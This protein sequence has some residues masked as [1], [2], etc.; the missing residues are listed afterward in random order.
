MK[1]K[2]RLFTLVIFLFG[3][4]NDQAQQIPMKIVAHRGASGYLPE[5]TLAAAAMA[6]GLGVDYIEPDLVM[7]KDDQLV[8]LHDIH[9]DTTTNVKE[10]F[11]NRK[12]KD[13]RYYAIDFTFK[14]L[15]QLKVQERIDLTTGQMVFPRRFPLHLSN[16]QIPHFSEFIELIQGLN[17]STGREVKIIPEIKSPEFHQQEGK[18]IAKKILDVLRSYGYE[19]N[20]QAIIQCFYPPTLL[21]LK[22]EFQTN[23]PLLQ[24]IADDSWAESTV[25][26]APML[27]DEGLKNIATYAQYLGPWLPQL[28]S[29]KNQKDQKIISNGVVAKAQKLGLKVYAYTHRV[30]ALPEFFKTNEEF[31]SFLKND[32]KLDGLFSD[33][34]NLAK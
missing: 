23:I 27:T 25:K 3:C 10:V 30:D 2:F 22:N 32:L 20:N 17:H 21:R 31:L 34:P 26:Y 12:R 1:K 33:F 6:F 11:P 18:D 7:T 24:L 29:L 15:Q 28:V 5:H 16:F 13:N 19:N 14:E 4:H 8:V 9:I